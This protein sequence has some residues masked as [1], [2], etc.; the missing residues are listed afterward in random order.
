[1]IIAIDGPAG[2]G[3]STV[4]RELA[5]RL[6]LVYLDTGAM[7]R[8][9]TFTALDRRIDPEDGKACGLLA[10]ELDLSF[11]AEGHILIDGQAGEPAIRGSAVT[12]GVS[13]I[14]AH[15]EVRRAVVRKQRAL[16]RRHGLVAE[17][18]DTTSVVFPEADHKFFLTATESE[19]ASRRAREEGRV[20]EVEA[21]RSE[22]E[23][24]DH[25]DS[26]RAHSP[27]T[28]ASDATLVDSD[29]LDVDGVVERML[30]HVQRSAGA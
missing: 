9:V 26:S 16:A 20:H 17:G 4:A 8:A 10:E 15:P 13:Q 12:R 29:G 7:Y 23:R 3:K 22:I 11:D 2:A 14:S 25:L 5:R 27:L 30:E 24:R 1:M 6:G 18:R 28:K 19:R 21:V